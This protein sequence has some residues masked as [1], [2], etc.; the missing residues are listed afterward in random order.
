VR[1]GEGKGFSG[2]RGEGGRKGR[3]GLDFSEGGGICA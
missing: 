3:E 2:V 1:N